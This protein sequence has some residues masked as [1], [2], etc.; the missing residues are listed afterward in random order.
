MRLRALVARMPPS[1]LQGL[2]LQRP[3]EVFTHRPA[4]SNKY[5]F[6][7]GI[8]QTNQTPNWF[9]EPN[10]KRSVIRQV[11]TNELKFIQVIFDNLGSNDVI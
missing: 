10:L 4:A 1:S 5:Q 9:S 8:H 7:Y 2:Y 6:S 11:V 3:A